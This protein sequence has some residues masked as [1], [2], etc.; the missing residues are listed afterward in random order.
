MSGQLKAYRAVKE[1]RIILGWSKYI[2][3]ICA[4]VGS[5]LSPMY[6]GWSI[7]IML[8]VVAVWA[9]LCHMVDGFSRGYVI[10]PSVSGL[11]F[12]VLA[13]VSPESVPLIIGTAV[14]IAV[15]LAIL[16]IVTANPQVERRTGGT[17][18]HIKYPLQRLVPLVYL[19]PEVLSMMFTPVAAFHWTVGMFGIPVMRVTFF[20]AMSVHKYI[21]KQT[22]GL[23]LDPDN[24]REAVFMFRRAVGILNL[25]DALH[26]YEEIDLDGVALAASARLALVEIS[27]SAMDVLVDVL[28][29]LKPSKQ[30]ILMGAYDLA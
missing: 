3:A 18:Y 21:K 7:G 5:W 11:I 28:K 19:A 13:I 22:S 14:G 23:L 30:E 26:K 10:Y 25:L 16:L 6:D 24:W 9:A 1:H 27:D 8:G 20:D 15:W 4:I 17:L 29:T 12:L 2:L